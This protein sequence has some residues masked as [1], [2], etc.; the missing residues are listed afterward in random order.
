MSDEMVEK[1]IL[2]GSNYMSGMNSAIEKTLQFQGVAGQGG[3][4]KGLEN[5]LKGAESTV[6]QKGGL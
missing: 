3:L 1:L 6:T 5:D 4:T 2:D